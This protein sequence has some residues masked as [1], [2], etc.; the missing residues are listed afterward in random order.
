[1]VHGMRAV[2][3]DYLDDLVLA[4]ERLQWLSSEAEARAEGGDPICLI[5]ALCEVYEAAQLLAGPRADSTRGVPP[6]LV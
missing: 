6:Q 5:D 2:P 1:M 3:A 4:V